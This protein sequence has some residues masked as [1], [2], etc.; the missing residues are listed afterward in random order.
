MDD[1]FKVKFKAIG[2][3][4]KIEAKSSDTAKELFTK[5]LKSKDVD[6]SK[7]NEVEFELDSNSKKISSDCKDKLIDLGILD[8]SI[9]KVYDKGNVFPQ[10]KER[11]KKSKAGGKKKMIDKKEE[12]K[13]NETML[14][15]VRDMAIFGFFENEKISK[16]LSDK[17]HEFISVESAL[18]LKN[19]DE[20]GFVLGLMGKYLRNLEMSVAIN[21]SEEGQDKKNQK[22]S[23]STL[24]FLANGMITKRKIKLSFDTEKNFVNNI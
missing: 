1:S 18:E 23:H 5:F 17:N 19:K 21:L 24:Q 12:E 22:S 20:Q 16:D 9:I 6:L 10:L 3:E 2:F 4:T 14:T 15:V 7:A 13:E 8:D 11:P